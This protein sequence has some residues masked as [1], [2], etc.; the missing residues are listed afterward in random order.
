MLIRHVEARYPDPAK[1]LD[2][3]A[4]LSGLDVFDDIHD[5]RGYLLDPNNWIP[6]EVLRGL[7]IQCEVLS[8]DKDVAYHAALAHYR[9]AKDRAPTL[10]ETIG[11]LVS[12]VDVLLKSAG[13]WASAYTNYMTLQTFTQGPEADTLY[14]LSH[15]RPPVRPLHGNIRLVQGNIEGV[16]RLDP[17]VA[18]ATCTEQF[19]QA[20]L[21]DLIAEFGDSYTLTKKPSSTTVTER[22][23]GRTILVA[24]PIT[25]AA[26]QFPAGNVG[27]AA[28]GELPLVVEPD[29]DGHLAVFAPHEQ[30]GRGERGGKPDSHAGDALV[31]EEEGTLTAGSLRLTV[32]AGTIFDAPYSRYCL[33][34]TKRS[35]AAPARSIPPDSLGNHERLA[36][37]LFDHLRNLQRTQRR[38]LDMVIQNAELT[39]ENIQLKQE[40]SHLQDTGG[41]IG[42]SATIQQALSL[43]RTVA[44]SDATV[45]ITGETGTGKEL[46]ARLIHRLSRRKDRRFVAVNCGA[47]PEA[48]LESELFGHERGAFTGAVLQKK[49]KFELADGGTL[50]LDEVGDISTAVQVKLLRVLQEKEFQRVGGIADLKSDVRVVA[51]TNRDLEALIEHKQFRSD[52]YY[53]LNVIQV[54]LPPLRERTDDIPDLATH[55]VQRYAGRSGKSIKGL[56]QEALALCLTYRWP[57]NIR[58]LENVMERAVT[59]AS[60]AAQRVTADLLPPAIRQSGAREVPAM[61]VTE[62]VD[63]LEWRALLQAIRKSGSLSTLLNQ[64]EWAITRRTVAE[65]G[66]NKSRAAKVLGRTYRWLRKLESEMTDRKPP[67]PRRQT[68]NV[69]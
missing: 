69:S 46:A 18:A 65:Y 37:L 42:R 55:F 52:L 47:V 54:D 11:L 16:A 33:S 27:G 30:K 59:L 34:W 2:H 10:L 29:T 9:E 20:R 43:I 5:P 14:L 60:E 39:Q 17:T 68:P 22:T 28:A 1:Q 3:R 38:T 4:L 41:I 63:R 6:H 62:F 31:I 56:G 12:N 15:Y 19:S 61:D 50:F 40:L 23:T 48:L 64:V 49:G 67:T 8:G 44:G 66:G 25:L 13:H 53:R 26:E 57:G 36:H 32:K 7:I 45:L 35:A 58:E 24:H 51:A 21:E